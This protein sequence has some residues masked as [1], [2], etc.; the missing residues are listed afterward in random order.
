[1]DAIANLAKATASDRAA[2]AQLAATVERITAELITVN[3]ADAG[4]DVDA[5]VDTDTTTP[6]LGPPTGT[7]AA[8]M[9]NKQDL[10]PPIYYCWT[11]G[12][13]CKHN[14]AKSPASVTGHVY[15]AA[16]RDM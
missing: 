14:S 12:P 10:E 11:W 2:I 8:T 6:T 4:A 13:G 5:D 15:T 16:K 3:T 9:T 1:M 7:R